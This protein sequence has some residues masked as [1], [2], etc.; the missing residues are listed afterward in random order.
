MVSSKAGTGK[1]SRE[2]FCAQGNRLHRKRPGLVTFCAKRHPVHKMFRPAQ[3]VPVHPSP[4]RPGVL[5]SLTVAS[6]SLRPLARTARSP[7]PRAGRGPHNAPTVAAALS[8]WT[9]GR[10]R[11]TPP[12]TP[13]TRS[14]RLGPGQGEGHSAWLS[15]TRP[16]P[17]Q[18]R[19]APAPA[20]PQDTSQEGPGQTMDSDPAI[21]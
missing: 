16:A 8:A 17:Q 21:R 6:D 20:A 7:G 11:V 19:A 15:S 1:V 5:G 13:A 3:N 4:A 10:E 14:R 12:Q 18:H 2:T 9:P